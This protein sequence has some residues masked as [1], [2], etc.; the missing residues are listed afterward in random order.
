[1]VNNANFNWIRCNWPRGRMDKASDF[2][3]EG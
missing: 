2:G 1:M 3:S